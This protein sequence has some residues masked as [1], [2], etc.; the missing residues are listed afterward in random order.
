M[1]FVAAKCITLKINTIMEDFMVISLLDLQLSQGKVVPKGQ[2]QCYIMSGDECV[3]NLVLGA[4]QVQTQ[5]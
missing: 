3:D 4:S 5:E 2:V 1:N